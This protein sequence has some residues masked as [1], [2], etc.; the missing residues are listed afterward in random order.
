[1]KTRKKRTR[2]KPK[3]KEPV[4]RKP[5]EEIPHKVQLFIEFL[6][7]GIM[8]IPYFMTVHH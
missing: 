6:K 1:M 4:E 2:Q 3:G 7:I 8:L 5:E